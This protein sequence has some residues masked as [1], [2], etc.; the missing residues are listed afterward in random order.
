[1]VWSP[2][3]SERDYAPPESLR[4][5]K[6]GQKVKHKSV[7]MRERTARRV[8]V[9]PTAHRP[10]SYDDQDS[11]VLDV[12]DIV[13]L[14][15]NVSRASKESIYESRK[16]FMRQMVMREVK[17]R[18]E[19]AS[20]SE[21]DS[22][23]DMEERFAE[24][25]EPIARFSGGGGNG[26][27]ERSQR[28]RRPSR[29]TPRRS[30]SVVKAVQIK[31]GHGNDTSRKDSIQPVK[32]QVPHATT[33]QQSRKD[34]SHHVY[35]NTN[36]LYQGQSLA[37]IFTAKMEARKA[38]GR[39][40]N[41]A[42]VLA[43]PL[44]SVADDRF[45]YVTRAMVHAVASDCE[46]GRDAMYLSRSHVLQTLERVPV[47]VVA[48]A[49]M[50]ERSN[51]VQ[52]R[53]RGR[54]QSIDRDSLGTGWGTCSTCPSYC[55]GEC[56]DC[57]CSSCDS[58]VTVAA[59]ATP[60]SRVAAK[61]AVE[62][63]QPVPLSLV[64]Q[65]KMEIEKLR[66]MQEQR[67]AG[68]VQLQAQRLTEDGNVPEREEVYQP[69]AVSYLRN[70]EGTLQ[71]S[72]DP[73][74][75][76]RWKVIQ[77]LK[78]KMK[79]V[80]AAGGDPELIRKKQS[81]LRGLMRRA[82]DAGSQ[83]LNNISLGPI[84]VPMVDRPDGEDSVDDDGRD[85]NDY[86]TFASID[87]LIFEPKLTT[88]EEI[89]EAQKSI[90]HH[91]EYLN[92]EPYSGECPDIEFLAHQPKNGYVAA[93]ALVEP[94]CS[95]AVAASCEDSASESESVLDKPDDASDVS[96]GSVIYQGEKLLRA[97]VECMQRDDGHEAEREDPLEHSQ[98][99][100]NDI[101]PVDDRDSENNTNVD[102]DA[103]WDYVDTKD[104]QVGS[105][106]DATGGAMS[107]CEL[108]QQEDYYRNHLKVYDVGNLRKKPAENPED[109]LRET[110]ETAKM[111]QM[112]RLV[113]DA[114]PSSSQRLL[115]PQDAEQGPDRAQALK[116]SFV[117]LS[118]LNSVL[119][120]N[121]AATGTTESERSRRISA[122]QYLQGD[123]RV[124]DEL[125]LSAH[126]AGIVLNKLAEE[127][128]GSGEKQMVQHEQKQASSR[129]ESKPAVKKSDTM[130]RELKMKL[131]EKFRGESAQ[132]QGSE[133][134]HSQA[135]DPP[136]KTNLAGKRD[137]IVPAISRFLGSLP[138]LN[139]GRSKADK[140]V[141]QPDQESSAELYGS[142]G[143]TIYDP[144]IPEDVGQFDANFESFVEHPLPMVPFEMLY[145][146]DPYPSLVD[147]RF[148][149]LY[150]WH[151]VPEA[152]YSISRPL[153]EDF[154]HE[155]HVNRPRRT[156]PIRRS[157]PGGWNYAEN[158]IGG[159]LPSP[160]TDDSLVM[161]VH[162]LSIPQGPLLR[163][164]DS[165]Q[166][167]WLQDHQVVRHKRFWAR[168]GRND[169]WKADSELLPRW[170]QF[171]SEE[172]YHGTHL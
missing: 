46:D 138:F 11:P 68:L 132:D 62:I 30:P 146:P 22:W 86:D 114:N 123:P 56:A 49:R 57:S 51:G 96:F 79:Q 27:S 171:H 31:Y 125:L 97:E 13:A 74:A 48:E 102:T 139:L 136:P 161:P 7:R 38:R 41:E 163:R 76:K 127:V 118:N 128:V 12:S 106:G 21:A 126:N 169:N 109:A 159:S 116:T 124:Y 35:E 5:E 111:L 72:R 18:R 39:P 113:S 70:E 69:V 43:K 80:L 20:G 141:S 87:T 92:R 82:M 165:Y 130:I 140:Q 36:A 28:E 151:Y 147:Q 77:Q 50:S 24:I 108:M 58:I 16:L 75:R 64:K 32:Q 154:L 60:K 55:D 91:F 40:P 104:D 63:P 15:D 152:L 105:N 66:A 88:Q 23:A 4:R 164:M 81:Q 166:D 135:R 14:D 67:L 110:E 45:Q 168:H 93:T 134:R 100:E 42:K 101:T 153:H 37:Q 172:D 129:L 1:M 34:F 137:T 90:A 9:S 98:S 29:S 144:S 95:N 2:A 131:K 25:Y 99:S 54:S 149:P 52:Q 83:T 119:L 26:V 33:E 115:F 121:C 167:H 3:K 103:S 10:D 71:D 156:T 155:R 120:D 19:N 150:D 157:D 78:Y 160:I 6:R 162:R 133:P 107:E 61:D 89:D 148:D 47:G 143:T 94:N 122:E 44:E 158:D 17:R 8:L 85:A 145:E 53:R 59:A 65:R 117:H 84:Y 112:L 73:N 170:Q 142:Q